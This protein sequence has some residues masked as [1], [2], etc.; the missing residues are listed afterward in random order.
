MS[1]SGPVAETRQF[2][3]DATRTRNDALPSDRQLPV[4]L[5]IDASVTWAL[6]NNRVLRAQLNAAERARLEV[7]VAYSATYA[8]RLTAS[9]QSTRTSDD[10]GS[11]RNNTATSQ[12]ALNTNLLGFT[13]A[14]YVS[15]SWSEIEGVANGTPY[16]AAAGVALSRRIFA[17]AEDTRLSQQLTSADRNYAKA[18]NSLTVQTRRTALDTA[19]AFFELQR[20]ESRIRLRESRLLQAKEFLA[21]VHEAVLAG[22]KAPIEETNAAIDANQAE[23]NL[24]ADRQSLANARDRLLSQLDRPLGG[25]VTIAPSDV[26]G[27]KPQLPPIAADITRVLTAHEDI[28]NLRIDQ[29]QARDDT[30]IAHDRVAPQVTATASAGRTWESDHL[31]GTDAPADVVALSVNV[32]MPLDGWAGERAGLGR[33]LRQERNLRLQRRTLETD[34]ERQVRELRRTIDVQI[35]SVDLAQQRREAEQAKFAATE[36]SYRTGRVDNLE[37]TRAREALDQA[38]VSLV[39]S[40][41]D[42]VLAL[43]EREALVPPEVTK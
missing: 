34:L 36:T 20:S 2:E 21:G 6:V 16:G 8:P 35:R 26:T 22:L 28:L 24:L 12:V 31:A 27:V 37:L 17:V 39:E 5:S 23:A 14:P 15:S 19:R 43:A 29:D 41:I 30:A 3:S 13:I 25:E 38:E 42:L 18:A 10:A 40:R 32:D 7:T 11:V 9:G 1:V 4:P 33:Q